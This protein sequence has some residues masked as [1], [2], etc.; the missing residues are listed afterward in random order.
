M[1]IGNFTLFFQDAQRRLRSAGIETPLEL[2]ETGYTGV[3]FIMPDD[4]ET[5]VSRMTSPTVSRLSMSTINLLPLSSTNQLPTPATPTTILSAQ[6]STTASTV[7]L[8]TQ[9]TLPTIQSTQRTTTTTETETDL[10][11]PDLTDFVI[12]T[13]FF[14]YNLEPL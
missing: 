11:V 8:P 12:G 3:L 6:I 9:P 14:I 4:L 1:L 13:Y 7:I 2:H 10:F 5:A